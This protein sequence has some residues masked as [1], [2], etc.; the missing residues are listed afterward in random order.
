ME[1]SGHNASG[2]LKR[3]VWKYQ[4][5]RIGLSK[6]NKGDYMSLGKKE[7]PQSP[8]SFRLLPSF[9]PRKSSHSSAE[10]REEMALNHSD[11]STSP[12]TSAFLK[13]WGF[14]QPISP[15]IVPLGSKARSVYPV[16]RRGARL[17]GLTWAQLHHRDEMALAT[18][19]P[20]SKGML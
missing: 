8:F 7:R 13:S 14:F 9:V 15:L 17:R 3:G 20:Y 5:M 10:G 12:K 1:F 6:E 16:Q 2:S 19:S 18:S 4:E 11:W